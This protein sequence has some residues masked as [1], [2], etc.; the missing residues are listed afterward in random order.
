MRV[1]LIPSCYLPRAL[2]TALA[3]PQIFKM[4]VLHLHLNENRF[5]VE[6]KVFPLLN[7]PQGC[8]E[9][10]FYT[11]DDI[12]QLV[13]FARDRGVRVIPEL[14]LSAH[15]DALCTAW[16]RDGVP[17]CCHGVYTAQ[18]P[19]D[20]GGNTSRLVGQLLAEMAALAMGCRV[21]QTPLSIFCMGNH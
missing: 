14:E 15:A 6:S 7:Q 20:A 13:A 12:T 5:R 17:T 3:M 11:Q 16:K 18:L 21:I 9:C 19:N 4:N 2:H 10:G 8:S 1:S